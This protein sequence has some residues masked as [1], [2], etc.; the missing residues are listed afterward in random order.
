MDA[1]NMAIK[2]ELIKTSQYN[3]LLIKI[4]I[5]PYVPQQISATFRE[6][7]KVIKILGLKTNSNFATILMLP[8][9]FHIPERKMRW[10]N[11]SPE[12]LYLQLSGVILT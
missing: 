5:W 6:V 3:N 2:P 7:Q 12:F 8:L 4:L 10:M 11:L 9:L 1:L